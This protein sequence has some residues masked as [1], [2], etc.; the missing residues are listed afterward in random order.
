MWLTIA[1]S[2]GGQSPGPQDTVKSIVTDLRNQHYDEALS[3]AKASLAAH[4]RDHRLWTLKGMAFEGKGDGASAL[5][6]FRHALSI[7]PDYAPALKAEAR[8]LF[9]TKDKQV[10]PLLQKLIQLDASDQ[11]AH[12]ML[13]IAN[14][15][16]SECKS[17]VEQFEVVKDSIRSNP[18]S[19]QWYGY[20]LTKE[21]QYPKAEAAFARLVEL[22]PTQTDPRFD[23]ALVRT[24]ENRNAEAL[25][26]LQPLLALEAPDVDV[27]SLASEVYEATGDTPKAVD[28]LRRAIQLSPDNADLYVRFAGICLA[29]DSFEVGIDVVNAGLKRIPNDASLYIARGL[30][31]GQIGKYADAEQDLAKAEKLNPAKT[32]SSFALAA[33]AIQHGDLDQALKTVREELKS[34]PND[35]RLRYMLAKVLTDQGAKPGTPEFDE[36]MKSAKMTVRLKPEFVPGHDLLAGL[37]LNAGNHELAAEQCRIALASDPSDQSALYHLIAALRSNGNKTELQG[38][39][40]QLLA[41]QHQKSEQPSARERYKIM[42]RPSNGPDNAAVP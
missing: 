32:T 1:G 42:E 14:A 18:D 20:C 13:A 25:E 23:L 31:Y 17:A 15:R 4:P 38:L 22:L 36:A 37:Y 6:A 28:A 11:T 39:V 35:P 19:L 5:T 7:A 41:L 27:L 2:V 34:H 21:K 29:H 30:L 3:E 12:E 8:L 16:Q 9:E 40:K 26:A 33:T 10:I 24:M